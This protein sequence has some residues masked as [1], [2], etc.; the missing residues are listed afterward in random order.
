M[1]R[2]INNDNV[3]SDVCARGFWVSGQMT[4]YDVTHWLRDTEI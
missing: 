1:E 3:R 2:G 4:F